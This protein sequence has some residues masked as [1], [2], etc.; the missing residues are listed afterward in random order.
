MKR[1]NFVGDMLSDHMDF[2]TVLKEDLSRLIYVTEM[3][4]LPYLYK[5]DKDLHSKLAEIV[6][7][8]KIIERQLG[9]VIRYYRKS[10]LDVPEEIY[11]LYRGEIFTTL[12]L[13]N[14]LLEKIK[15]YIKVYY[16]ALKRDTE[17][18][19]KNELKN[20]L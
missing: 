3:K 2:L 9:I 1:P 5:M 7:D 15:E 4:L 20:V 14:R 17:H 11:D 16:D 10:T 8:L 12:A 6:L 19:A 18:F 13:T